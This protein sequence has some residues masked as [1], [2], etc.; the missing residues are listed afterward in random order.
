MRLALLIL[1]L[2]LPARAEPL[3][4]AAIAEHILPGT[5][6][7]SVEADALAGAAMEDC[8]PE[9]TK[10]RAAYHKAFDAWVAVSHLRFGPAED[11][12]RAFALAFW[13][14]PRGTTAKTLTRL[15]ATEDGTVE[16]DAAFARQSVAV[17]GFY[18]LERM[19]YD[20][21][22]G[23][24]AYAC[25]LTQAIARGIARTTASM[26]REWPAHAALMRAP[27]AENP[28]YLGMGEVR[29]ALYTALDT[30]LEFT[31]ATRLGRPLGSLDKPRPKRA[32]AW[33]S[34][35]SLRQV[36]LS[37]SASRALASTLQAGDK[38][39]AAFARALS[40]AETLDDPSFA[41]VSDPVGRLRVEALQQSVLAIRHALAT[42]LA[43][44]LGVT[45]GF[46]SLDGD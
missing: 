39:D 6:K 7:L 24:A 16:T 8:S 3:V 43:P 30:G 15:L 14:D 44:R 12:D 5:E 33:R 42:E 25:R 26:A 37:L 31:A 18:A 36:V 23:E 22:A 40:R 34:G 10:L 11:E 32:E 17:R 41:G 20:P 13:P 1:L 9:S 27:G 45:A 2:T 4:D 38:V 28:V 29:R 21:P 35:R 19:L 46:N